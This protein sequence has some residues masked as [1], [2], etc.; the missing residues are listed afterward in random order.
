MIVQGR[1]EG[2]RESSVPCQDPVKEPGDQMY[3]V[4]AQLQDLRDHLA[5]EP[6]AKQHQTADVVSLH[7]VAYV[8]AAHISIWFLAEVQL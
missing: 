3:I 1:Y 8:A 6:A 4:A 2:V 5:S 7:L